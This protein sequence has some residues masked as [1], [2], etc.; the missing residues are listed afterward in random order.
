MAIPQDTI[1]RRIQAPEDLH[2]GQVPIIALTV[3]SLQAQGAT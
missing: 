3:Y 1:P 2:K